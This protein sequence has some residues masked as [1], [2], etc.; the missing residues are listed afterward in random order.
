MW[1]A[2]TTA[3]SR[4]AG[5]HTLRTQAHEMTKY[6]RNSDLER[7][8]GARIVQVGSSGS[9]YL[10]RAWFTLQL[11]AAT[12]GAACYT[13]GPMEKNN[14]AL[15]VGMRVFRIISLCDKSATA[16]QSPIMRFVPNYSNFKHSRTDYSTR[17][18]CVLIFCT[19][20]CQLAILFAA[21]ESGA[22]TFWNSVD[23]ERL[24]SVDVIRA[25]DSMVAIGRRVSLRMRKKHTITICG[26]IIIIILFW[27]ARTA[28]KRRNAKRGRSN[29]VTDG[30]ELKFYVQISRIC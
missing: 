3:T 7:S 24:V 29:S 11:W 10:K 25:A 2:S 17:G 6:S 8:A 27:G 30:D 5:I 9:T 28:T 20:K 12:T 26:Y 16:Y 22:L 18:R 13:L 1:C 15:E 21:C 4:S 23:S 14:N 19:R